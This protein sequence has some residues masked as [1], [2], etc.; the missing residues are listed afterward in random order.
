M[1]RDL[2]LSSQAIDRFEQSVTAT[3]ADEIRSQYL[4]RAY[5][6][7]AQVDVGAWD[8]AEQTIRQ[9]IPLSREVA[10]TRTVVLLRDIPTAAGAAPEGSRC[11]SRDVRTADGHLGHGPSMKPSDREIA[12]QADPALGQ[13]FLVSAEKLV[14]AGLGRRHPPDR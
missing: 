5:L 4:H 14:R 9:L 11:L 2:G 3:P 7:Q 13:H 1:Q 10:S 6:L 12:A 8:A